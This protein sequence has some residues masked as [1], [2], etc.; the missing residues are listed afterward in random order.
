MSKRKVPADF[1][2]KFLSGKI[3]SPGMESSSTESIPSEHKEHTERIRPEYQGFKPTEL[4]HFSIRLRA[5]DLAKL[6]EHFERADIPM[7]QGV[8]QIVLDYM[9]AKGLR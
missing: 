6:R 5:D 3:P 9:S 7:S 8:R 2:D 1:M 4:V